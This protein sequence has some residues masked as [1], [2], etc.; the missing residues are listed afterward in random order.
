MD[1]AV[2][3][4]IFIGGVGERHQFGGELTKNKLLI[5]RLGSLGYDVK[6]IDTYGSHRNPLKIW[7]LPVEV[8]SDRKSPIFFSTSYGNIRLMATLIHRLN[9]DRRLVLWVIGGMLA[10]QI[11]RG[12]YRV[13]EF[14]KF[15]T[16]IVE[17]KAMR[18][19]MISCGVRNVVYAPNFKD[20]TYAVTVDKKNIAAGDT[21]RCVFFSRIRPEK[22]VDIILDALESG[23]LKDKDLTV[24]FYGEIQPKY[25]QRFMERISRIGKAD[26]RGMLDFFDGSG[27]KILSTYHLS[28]FPTYWVGEGLPGVIIDAFVAGVPVLASDW[29]FNSE[30][31]TPD[32]GFLCEANNTD[33]F[34]KKL[35]D[36]C[37]NLESLN[38]YFGRCASQGRK[39]DVD[40]VV[41]KEFVE[42]IL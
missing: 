4:I 19:R 32:C 31:V 24:D 41:N 15:S 9:P 17:S 10:D 38:P 22:G 34:Q 40:S 30:Y 33:D 37:A 28:L 16:V 36:L 35:N 14:D 7:R 1:K 2:S 11:A 5:K 26:Y 21:L 6:V 29:N 18:E 39:Y 25:R 3:K 23:L 20:M 13:S 12:E 8:I 27:Q 42:E